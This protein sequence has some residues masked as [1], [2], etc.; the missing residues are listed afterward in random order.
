MDSLCISLFGQFRVHCGQQ[1]LTPG[2]P[3]RLQ[4]LFAYLLLHRDHAHP[5]ENL[6]SL[7]WSDCATAQSK[8]YLR[9]ALWQLQT[10]IDAQ[11]EPDSR[12]LL[13]VDAERVRLNPDADLWLDVAVFERACSRTRDIAGHMLDSTQV[14]AV[15]EAVGLYRGELLEGWFQD[16]CL[17]ERERL[18]NLYLTMLDKLMA[19]CE[20]CG[21]YESGLAHGARVLRYDGARERTHRRLMRLHYLAGDRTAAL[22]QYDRCAAVLRSD[23]AVKPTARTVQLYEQIRTGRLARPA[24]W[25]ALDVDAAASPSTQLPQALEHLQELETVLSE[26]QAQLP[27]IIRAVELAM[28]DRT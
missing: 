26:V 15:R 21:E 25:S 2:Y 20:A 1:V 8:K 14:G 17:Y 5:R 18:Q 10:V 11:C 24:H 27:Y 4:E 12:R 19:H 6:A 3:R 9:Q 22:R 23:L 7:L 28:R 16:W 13:L